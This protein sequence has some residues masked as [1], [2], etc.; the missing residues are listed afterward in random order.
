M[1]RHCVWVQVFIVIRLKEKKEN[2]RPVLHMLAYLIVSFSAGK[3][4]HDS[5]V[6]ELRAQE[7]HHI[8]EKK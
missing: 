7:R 3:R 8:K 5:R 4:K 1:E 2:D 6:P